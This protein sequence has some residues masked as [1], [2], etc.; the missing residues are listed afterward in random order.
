MRPTFWKSAT[1]LLLAVLVGWPPGA[2]TQEPGQT[3]F[4]VEELEQL[5]APIAL[6]PD[7]LVAQALMASTYP[8]DIVQA[9]RFAKENAK[10]T[11][12]QLSEALKH[13]WDDSVKSPVSFP[14][15]LA[16]LAPDREPEP[17]AAPARA[18][19]IG[20]AA[21]RA[22]SGRL[23]RIARAERAIALHPSGIARR[24]RGPR[25]RCRCGCRRR[26]CRRI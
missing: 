8:L 18:R 6:Y 23:R 21:A 20:A 5:V 22:L 26:C 17:S 15:V 16:M 25:S 19:W 3:A 1:A 2:A 9:A 14:Q 24:F 13:P 10:L 12:D 4:K 7:A 11:G